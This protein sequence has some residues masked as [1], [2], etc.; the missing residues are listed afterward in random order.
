MPS[1]P[2][3]TDDIISRVFIE[4]SALEQVVII[5]SGIASESAGLL[6]S[7]AKRGEVPRDR[8]HSGQSFPWLSKALGLLGHDSIFVNGCENKTLCSSESQGYFRFGRL[9]SLLGV[10]VGSLITRDPNMTSDPLYGYCP[11]I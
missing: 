8:A 4:S 7:H 2:V 3:P 10:L 1:L 6:S 9:G 5:L 11:A